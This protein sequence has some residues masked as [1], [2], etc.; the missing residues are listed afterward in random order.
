MSQLHA[1]IFCHDD[2]TYLD[3]VLLALQDV[4]V[5]A[6]IS[7]VAWGKQA[8]GDWESTVAI[9]ESRGADVQLGDWDSE[10]M[11]RVHAL[12][13]ARQNS[14][15]FLLIPDSDEI[16]SKELLASLH[17]IASVD[18]ADVV[19]CTM[20]TFWKSPEYVIR[21]R[22]RLL[23]P[24]LVKPATCQ[25]VHL[26]E[27]RGQK[28]LL[29]P[30][31]HGVLFHMSYAGPESRILRKIQSWGH[32]DEVAPNWLSSIWNRWNQERTLQ[33]LHPT[34]PEAYR[35]A[36]RIHI[37]PELEP[38]WQAYLAACAG[39]D[40]LHQEE[41]LWS[42]GKEQPTLSVVIPLH[43]GEE[44]I[45]LCLE[46]LSNSNYP[47]HEVIVVDDAS[48]DG[49]AKVAKSFGRVRLIKNSK[50]EGFAR[51]CNTGAAAATGELLLLLNSDTI[52][53]KHSIAL[54]VHSLLRSGTNGAVGPRSNNIGH[55]QPIA[56]TYSTLDGIELF[57]EDQIEC[58]P[59]DTEHDMLV[60]FSLL[61]RKSTWEEV[62]EF[63]TRFGTGMFEDNDLCHRLR[64]EGYR[65]ILC[66]RAFVHH[67]GH[68]SLDR[69]NT[70]KEELFEKNFSLYC[71]KWEEDIE[72]GFASGLAGAQSER[73]RFD[74]SRKPE[75]LKGQI[76]SLAAKANISLCMIVKNEERVLADCLNS[77]SKFF[78]QVI[79][80]DTGSTDATKEIA[81]KHGA[82]V[83]E[84]V[85]PDSFSG[86]RNESLRHAT[87]DWICWLDADDTLPARSGEAILRAVIAA[88]P[89]IGGLVLPV[90]FVN[91]DPEY[92]TTVDHVKVFRN[93]PGIAFEGRIHEQILGSIRAAGFDV[94]RTQAEVLHT[95]YDTSEEGQQRKR[96]RDAKLL[97][98]DLEDR[99]DHPFVLF[100]LGMTAHYNTEHEDAAEWLQ[101]SIAVSGANESHIRK[102]YA[103][104]AVSVRELGDSEKALEIV[105][106]GLKATPDDPELLFHL[107]LLSSSLSRY[108]ESAKAY[109]RLLETGR[110]MHFSSIDSGLF[111]FKTFHNLAWVY[112]NMKNYASARENFLKAM[113][114]NPRYLHSVFDLFRISLEVG[115]F[116]TARQCI[117]HVRSIEGESPNVAGMQRDLN[118][119][120]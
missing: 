39:N 56:S 82:Q 20:D 29:L 72:S 21:P 118:V 11:Q 30:A 6:F 9:C 23:P 16:L 45:R 84:I 99:P 111:G 85:W 74:E 113:E 115:D 83:H 103:L 89:Q 90:R 19:H 7:R 49:A 86:A 2:N 33:N 59:G 70:N 61:I 92:G 51:T 100:N 65:L 110:G 102:A 26:R 63:D 106:E 43:G 98:L 95:G 66:N 87:G 27:Y 68:A 73:I 91:D 117:E 37:H 55:F 78:S 38:A 96:E 44:D 34:H 12:E 46:S 18:L 112:W 120:G 35:W 67:K 8:P 52:V 1:A 10:D 32:K 109:E 108:E 14:V 24:I 80:V 81:E 101:R 58:A 60:G 5:T 71:Q 4:P 15:E 40:P 97:L 75:I 114:S 22:E 47:I 104:W 93:V 88:P 119:G 41:F 105:G 13:W 50:N 31:E 79:V 94:A 25:H 62:G 76:Q 42:K 3:A 28:P 17:K 36:E 53:P 116:D 48:P 57:A 77:A 64:R 107:G 54:M 69:A